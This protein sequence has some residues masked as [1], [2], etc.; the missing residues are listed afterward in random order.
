M[1][2][3]AKR[4]RMIDWIRFRVRELEDK[5]LFQPQDGFHGTYATLSN[6]FQ[7]LVLANQVPPDILQRPKESGPSPR[8]PCRYDSINA[9]TCNVDL[10]FDFLDQMFSHKSKGQPE[11]IWSLMCDHSVYTSVVFVSRD[12]RCCFPTVGQRRGKSATC[13]NVEEH[14]ASR[15]TMLQTQ[16]MLTVQKDMFC[17][18][19]P[20]SCIVWEGV[21]FCSIAIVWSFL[22][23]VIVCSRRHATTIAT[24]IIPLEVWPRSVLLPTCVR[25]DTLLHGCFKEYPSTR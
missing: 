7:L 16:P 8:T 25:T 21:V 14:V 11:S 19:L 13:S 12:C 23:Y 9:T 10:R 1:N 5:V 24:H 18:A 3:A 6:I 20:L 22:V 15:N 17:L 2:T 4:E